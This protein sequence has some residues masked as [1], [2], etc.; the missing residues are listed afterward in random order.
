MPV[1]RIGELLAAPQLLGEE[2]GH[3]VAGGEDDGAGVGLERLHDHAPRRRAPAAAGEL[4]DELEGTLLGAEVRHREAGIG[5]DD[6]GEG[7]VVEVVPLGDHLSAE[8]DGAVGA[9][10][11]LQ[12]LLKLGGP[13]R[14]VGVEPDPLEPGHVLLQ[15]PL[16]P[17]RSGADAD[18]LR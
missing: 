5:V 16:E 18:E 14:R 1:G 4:G 12:R 2:A 9:A 11:A 6:C 13:G 10:E 8:Q 7:D 17:L 3:V 15:I